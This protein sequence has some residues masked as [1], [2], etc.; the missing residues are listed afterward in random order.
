MA[1]RKNTYSSITVIAIGAAG[2]VSEEKKH[3]RKRKKRVAWGKPWL[4]KRQN[5][6]PSKHYEWFSEGRSNRVQT[7]ST[8]R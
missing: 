6:V 2:M 1:P 5:M 3:A 4:L 8:Y 7:V